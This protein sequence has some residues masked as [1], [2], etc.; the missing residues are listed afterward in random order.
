MS[1]IGNIKTSDIRAAKLNMAMTGSEENR[2]P[3]SYRR[4]M[5]FRPRLHPEQRR[6]VTCP[7]YSSVPTP[8]LLKSSWIKYAVVKLTV[9]A[10]SFCK[11]SASRLGDEMFIGEKT[12]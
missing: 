11:C 3:E 10:P 8:S 12:A 2:E 1:D 5:V 9:A 4:V 6:V 7:P